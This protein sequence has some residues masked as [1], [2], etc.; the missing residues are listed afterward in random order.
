VVGD[1]INRLS[2]K[3]HELFGVDGSDAR[4]IPDPRYFSIPSIV[5]SLRNEAL[6]WT[7]WVRIIDPIAIRLHKLAGRYH[8]GMADHGDQIALPARFDPQHAKAIL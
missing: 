2:P 5:I 3:A 1:F 8:R 6:N 7:P 4:I